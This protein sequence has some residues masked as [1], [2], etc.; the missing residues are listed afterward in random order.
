[1]VLW[2]R[3]VQP[4][5]GAIPGAATRIVEPKTDR[6]G[7]A[8]EQM[9]VGMQRCVVERCKA[10][11]GRPLTIKEHGKQRHQQSDAQDRSADRNRSPMAMRSG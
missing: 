1:M 4:F 8:F 3:H 11:L 7:L 2:T 9:N 6:N 5:R 10:A